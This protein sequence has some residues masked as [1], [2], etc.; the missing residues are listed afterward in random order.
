MTAMNTLVFTGK[1]YGLKGL[2][3]LSRFKIHKILSRRM[4]PGR[5]CPI[6]SWRGP[7][8]EPF[9]NYTDFAI[10]PKARCPQCG[11]LERHRA[12]KLF[13]DQF[14]ALPQNASLK[15]MIHFSPEDCLEGVL[16]KH[17][18]EYA[19]SDYDNPRD[20]EWRLDLRD[21][22]LPD[23]SY[24]VFLMNRV[25]SCMPED[26]KAA[27]SMYRVLRPGGVVLAGEDVAQDRS[28]LELKKTG[29]GGLRRLYGISDF[30]ERFRPFSVEVIDVING[31]GSDNRS[32]YGL[33]KSEWVIVLRKNPL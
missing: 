20:G 24:D 14:F 21:L 29:Y 5:T 32:K 7:E 27:Q 17:A 25:L 10:R 12:I 33:P 26:V 4:G 9:L 16:K 28:T 23:A 1:H 8:Y 13:Y 31:H 11:A 30:K 15:K 19:K 22:N 6:C 2:L 3:L 18:S